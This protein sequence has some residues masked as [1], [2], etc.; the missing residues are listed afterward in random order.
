M[1]RS[2]QYDIFVMYEII[3]CPV[4]G[5]RAVGCLW[6]SAGSEVGLELGLWRL[7]H[8]P[9]RGRLVVGCLW[10]SCGP[11]LGLGL[12][13]WCPSYLPLRG[14]LLLVSTGGP[15]V[16]Q[17]WALRMVFVAPPTGN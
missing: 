3:M 15:L 10:P 13:L 17:Y 11:V 6:P 2:D 8:L 4:R 16:G 9:L 5:H 7:S 14:L 1:P 12:G